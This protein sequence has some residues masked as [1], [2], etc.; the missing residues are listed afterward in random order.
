MMPVLQKHRLLTVVFLKTQAQ[1]WW[2]KE[3]PFP[4]H[5][6]CKGKGLG[7]KKPQ[8]NTCEMNINSQIKACDT[9]RTKYKS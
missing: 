6:C 9:A 4:Q 3:V 1:K 8:L 2:V 7:Q 5:V